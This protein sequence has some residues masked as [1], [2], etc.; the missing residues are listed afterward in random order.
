MNIS[1]KN[2]S[3]TESIY[4]LFKNLGNSLQFPKPLIYFLSDAGL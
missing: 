4:P 1:T 3:I 2:V